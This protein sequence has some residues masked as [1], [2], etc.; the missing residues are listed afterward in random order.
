MP[1]HLLEPKA[2]TFKHQDKLRLRAALAPNVVADFAAVNPDWGRKSFTAEAFI[3]EWLGPNHLGIKALATHHLLGTPYFK[4]ATAEEIVVEWQQMAS[5]ARRVAG[6]DFTHPMCKIEAVSDGRS[7]MQQT[8]VKVEGQWRIAV[9][10]PEIHY[11]AGNLR[12]IGR[13]DEE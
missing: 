5:H 12:E 2:L 8:L 7:W 6:E 4:S 1:K 13:P 3:D 9:I 10:K 11:R